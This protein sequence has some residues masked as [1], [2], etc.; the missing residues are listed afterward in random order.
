[1]TEYRS[2][3]RVFTAPEAH[4]GDGVELRRAFPG[5]ALMDLDPFLL[6]DQMGPMDVA[7]GKAR[8]FPPHPHR[9]FETVTYLLSGEMQHRDSWGNHGVLRPGDVQWMTAGSGLVHSELPGESLV[10][11]GGR[12]H[13]FQL[14]INLPRRDKMIRPRYQDTTAARIPVA[15]NGDGTVAAKVIA[16]EALGTK[17]VIDTRIPILYVHLTLQPGAEYTQEVP[18]SE[19]AFAFVIEGEGRF[20]NTRAGQYGVVLFDRGG[21]AVRI[22]NPGKKPLSLLLIAGEPIGEPVAR[23]GPFVMNSRDELQQAVADFREGRMGV[24]A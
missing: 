20:A 10:R 8:G 4:D 17:G 5:N 12:L 13:G 16:G 2:V 15:R 22:S 24:L 7:P 21:D 6:L 3:A 23:Y 14:W 9:G 19:N 18:R 11:D 1:M